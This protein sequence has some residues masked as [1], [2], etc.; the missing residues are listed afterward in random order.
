MVK[1]FIINRSFDFLLLISNNSNHFS[2][3][4]KMLTVQISYAAQQSCIL[5]DYCFAYTLT[6]V[7]KN[8]DE[9]F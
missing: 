6:N 9:Q 1:M 2:S 7:D 4:L 3:S 8:L 5:D